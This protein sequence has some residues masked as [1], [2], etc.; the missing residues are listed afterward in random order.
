MN[1]TVAISL[2]KVNL[3]VLI[4][5]VLPEDTVSQNFHLDPSSDLMSKNG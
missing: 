4:H 1:I 2:F 3:S 5:K